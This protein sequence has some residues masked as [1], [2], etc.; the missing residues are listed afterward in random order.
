MGL[1]YPDAKMPTSV[2]E[3]LCTNTIFMQAPF[4]TAFQV[5]CG[6]I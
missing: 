5:N 4:A 1:Q 6:S 2:H 3:F